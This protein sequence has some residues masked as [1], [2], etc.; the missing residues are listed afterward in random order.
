MLQNLVSW[1]YSG[2]SFKLRF[3]DS[4]VG[5]ITRVA[6]RG[7][8]LAK[9]AKITVSEEL[10]GRLTAHH[11]D[12][13]ADCLKVGKGPITLGITS[14]AI[15]GQFLMVCHLC[16]AQSPL[17]VWCSPA[18]AR[19]RLPRSSRLSTRSHGREEQCLCAFSRQRMHEQISSSHRRLDHPALPRSAPLRNVIDNHGPRQHMSEPD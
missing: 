17:I 15:N 11:I 12:I 14:L 3:D 2:G 10:A 9:G 19:L 18:N 8:Q 1:E 4:V 5:T 16:L 6:A 7:I 13:N